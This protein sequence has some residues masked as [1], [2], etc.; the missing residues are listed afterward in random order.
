MLKHD[1]GRDDYV[2]QLIAEASSATETISVRN[3]DRLVAEIFLKWVSACQ[4][5]CLFAAPLSRKP[6]QARRLPTVHLDGLTSP[7]LPQLVNGQL[8]AAARTHE[9]VALIFPDIDTATAIVTRA[10]TC[11]Q[12]RPG[13]GIGRDWTMNRWTA[14]S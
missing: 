9:A 3:Y 11:A 7:D 12:T 2:Q 1:A 8:D 10:T 14:C 13:A 4:T 5:A 6:R